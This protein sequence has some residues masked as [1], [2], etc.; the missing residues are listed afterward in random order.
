[1]DLSEKNDGTILFFI[2]YDRKKGRRNFG[3][4]VLIIEFYL[5]SRLNTIG[6]ALY[7]LS[8]IQLDKLEFIS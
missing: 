2:L 3:F 1:M 7:D 6:D 8:L 4:H 5:I